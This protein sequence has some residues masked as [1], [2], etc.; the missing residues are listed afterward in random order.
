MTVRFTTSEPETKTAFGE[1]DPET[2]K[3]P[4]FWTSSDETISMSLNYADPVEATV[5]KD[6]ETS[7]KADF[8][9]TFKDTGSP[10]VFYA[11]S[12]ISA[13]NALSSSRNSWTVTIPTVQTP[14]ADGLSCDE[15]AML[16]YSMS[17]ELE[18]LPEGPVSLHFAHATTYCRLGLRNLEQAFQTNG[19]ADATVTSVDVT[20][21]VPVAGSWYL[22]PSTGAMEE[23][24]SSY[25]I[26]LKPSIDD[27]SQ[28]TDIWFAM[29][30][31]TLDG[32]SV[33]VRVNT[34][35]GSLVREFTYGTRTYEAGSVNR[36]SLDMTKNSEFVKYEN[37][38]KETVYSLVT[39][40]S[41]LGVNDEIIIVDAVV[42]SYALGSVAEGANGIVS[43]SKGASDGFSYNATEGYVTLPENSAVAV[44][45][46]ASKN[47]SSFTFKKGNTFL[48]R[49]TNGQ[50]HYL[51]YGTQFAFTVAVSESGSGISYKS[52]RTTYSVYYDASH[53]KIFASSSG[54]LKTCAFFKKK[55]I[56]LPSTDPAVDPV[57]EKTRFGAYLTSGEVL[58]ESGISQ[59]GREYSSSGL[60]F[61]VLYPD[62]NV[63]VEFTGIPTSAATGDEFQLSLDRISGRKKTNIGTYSVTVI[64]EE[65]SKLWLTDFRG[66][67]FIVKR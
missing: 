3:Y 56:D 5:I 26:T 62:D 40:L 39:D 31:C 51:S 67:G 48:S 8:S 58:H 66:N 54:V 23:K 63:V 34:E 25:T 44:M 13:V 52:G 14:K 55:T 57:L 38:R 30:P 4:A 27:L 65:G 43:V 37:E 33:K 64:K 28:P 1:Q 46:V 11:M 42:P 12:P 50:S 7:R 49:S 9:A 45:S 16:L 47:G 19:V 53:F 22:D 29:A 10:Y 35:A 59:V 24:E 6:S 36:L 18:E 32:Q 60:T 21:S 17:A 41:D 61:S 2:M 15:S 20:Y